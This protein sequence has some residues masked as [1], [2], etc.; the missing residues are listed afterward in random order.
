[1]A[2]VSSR[3]DAAQSAE[4]AAFDEARPHVNEARS[5]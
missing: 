5:R 4:S 2:G 1:M 3:A